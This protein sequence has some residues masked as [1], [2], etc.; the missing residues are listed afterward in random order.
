MKLFETHG[1]KKIIEFKWPLIFEYTVKKLFMPFLIYLGLYL[2]LMHWVFYL[3]EMSDFGYGV[4]IGAIL[5]SLYFLG[6]EIY[7][8]TSAGVNYFYSF[9]NYLDIV[10]PV[11]MIIFLYL[12]NTNFFIIPQETANIEAS[13]QATISLMMW[14]KVLYFMRIF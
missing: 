14:L 2:V 8:V 9:W 13:I 3:P 12:F 6:I 5:F 1:V 7:Q 10:P 11:L 4:Q